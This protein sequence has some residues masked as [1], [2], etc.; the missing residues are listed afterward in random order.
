MQDDRPPYVGG[1][2]AYMLY[3]T[4]A[5]DIRWEK[6]SLG[7]ADVAGRRDHNIV[8]A[9]DMVLKSP[10]ALSYGPEKFVVPSTPM[11]P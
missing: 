7:V 11:T 4:S 6:P 1:N 9:S 5:D 2:A 8:F 3:F 10:T